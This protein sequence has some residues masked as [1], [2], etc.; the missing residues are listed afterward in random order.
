MRVAGDQSFR[1]LELLGLTVAC[2]VIVLIAW[3]ALSEP[4]GRDQ[5]IYL[6]AGRQILSGAAPHRDIF[7]QRPPGT[8]L[9][10]ALGMGLFGESMRAVRSLDLIWCLLSAGV[11]YL[12]GWRTFGRW[13]GIWAAL[14]FGVSYE[15][16]FNW[17]DSA[18]CDGLMILPLALAVYSSALGEERGRPLAYLAAGF[19]LGLAMWFK[20]SAA[21][22]ALPLG[23]VAIARRSLRSAFQHGLAICAGFLSVSLSVLGAFWLAGGLR[24]VIRQVYLFNWSVYIRP[25]FDLE[26]VRMLAY[27]TGRFLLKVHLLFVLAGLAATWGVA[28]ELNRR[29]TILLVWTGMSFVMTWIQWKLFGYHWTPIIA[30]LAVLAGQGVMLLWRWLGSGSAVRW[31]LA[32]R[33][34]SILLVALSLGT[35]VWRYLPEFKLSV[36]YMRGAM[37]EDAYLSHFVRTDFDYLALREV[38]AA[39]AANSGPADTALM[40]G[41]EPLV[42]FLADR[43]APSR[44]FFTFPVT[45]R[46]GSEV[47]SQ[48]WA[49]EFMK[50]VSTN[51]PAVI[52]LGEHDANPIMARSSVEQV[53]QWPAMKSFLAAQYEWTSTVSGYRLY[54]PKPV[55]SG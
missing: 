14:L 6:Y 8:V 34:A 12:I 40:W 3:P 32:G 29:L 55:G 1:W 37:S 49:D 33:L 43:Q 44:F 26:L 51:M 5:G 36:G 16:L 46:S 19:F 35:Y 45:G 15:L 2:V 11:I 10:Y 21:G 38:A 47:Y 4:P 31:R 24:D 42:L 23:L 30:P 39:V 52:V 13:A 28:R 53:E 7:D 41:V 27:W 50:D 9:V 18:A 48:A 54:Q 22:I 17:W 20:P 25:V